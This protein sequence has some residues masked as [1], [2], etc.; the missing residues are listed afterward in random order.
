[1]VTRI[2]IQFYITINHACFHQDFD[3]SGGLNH[4]PYQLSIPVSMAV[5]HKSFFY[6]LYEGS[7]AESSIYI[8]KI[9]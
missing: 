8:V 5:I 2:V 7:R 3:L 4:L 6:K 9:T 1:M